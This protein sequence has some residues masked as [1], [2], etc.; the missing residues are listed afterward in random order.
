[1]ATKFEAFNSRG[2]DYRTSHDIEDIIYIIDNRTT[3]VEEI[4]KA[5]GWISGFL[6]AEIQYSQCAVLTGCEHTEKS[7]IKAQ[8]KNESIMQSLFSIL[9]IIYFEYSRF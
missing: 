6:K 3:I 5:D 8:D 2:K 4:A 7:K 9:V 1:M